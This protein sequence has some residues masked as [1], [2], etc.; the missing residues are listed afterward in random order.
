MSE[1][2]NKTHDA[3]RNLRDIADD[4]TRI[5]SAF[6]ATGN[7]HMYSLLLHVADDIIEQERAVIQALSDEINRSCHESHKAVG[8]TLKLVLDSAFRSAS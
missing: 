4:L 5:A 6:R 3:A 8:E 7:D 2:I 1:Y